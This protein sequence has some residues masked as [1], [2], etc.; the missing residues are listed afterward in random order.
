M[1]KNKSGTTKHVQE[2]CSHSDECDNGAL[3]VEQNSNGSNVHH[4][5]TLEHCLLNFNAAIANGPKYVCTVCWQ[6][7]L[8][9]TVHKLS[10]LKTNSEHQRNLLQRCSTG[11]TSVDNMQW[12]CHTC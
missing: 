11:K 6:T 4:S 7:W 8:K 1:K 5:A 9:K 2:N 3:G 12:I 10:A